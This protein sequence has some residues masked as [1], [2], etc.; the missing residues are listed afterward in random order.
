MDIELLRVD[1]VPASLNYNSLPPRQSFLCKI[2]G[3]PA[4]PMGITC[5][6]NNT[7]RGHHTNKAQEFLEPSRRRVIKAR[8]REYP[9]INL[10]DLDR[11]QW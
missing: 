5:Q 4:I 6:F 11:E 1:Y 8:G 10:D 2:L 7:S 9:T 3:S